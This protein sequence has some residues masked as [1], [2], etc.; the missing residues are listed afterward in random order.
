MNSKVRGGP[1]ARGGYDLS[2][3][4]PRCGTGSKTGEA[5]VLPSLDLK[6]KVMLTLK[7]EYLV[8]ADLAVRVSSIASHVL[9]RTLSKQAGA[10]E[11]WFE[12]IPEKTLP[13]FSEVS[14]GFE[15]ERQCPVCKRDGFFNIPHV[16]LKL[17]YDIEREALA[18]CHLLETFECFGNSRLLPLLSD[19]SFAAP[20]LIFS[21]K[22]KVLFEGIRE[23]E[24]EEVEFSQQTNRAKPKGS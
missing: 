16:P 4:C 20:K 15:V 3:G 2:L 10:S 21:E 14:T 11:K 5:L 24:F 17:V 1:S 23:V 9:R 13:R 12:L 6:K 7:R 19:C 18:G 8:S 22:L